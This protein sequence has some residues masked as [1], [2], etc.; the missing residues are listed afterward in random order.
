MIKVRNNK[1]RLSLI[2]GRLTTRDKIE[3]EDGLWLIDRV[4]QLEEQL[5]KAHSRYDDVV[6]E[7]M[8]SNLKIM[9]YQGVRL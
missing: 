2:K 6:V 5:G 8:N 3:H 1:A 9:K 7:L 4:D